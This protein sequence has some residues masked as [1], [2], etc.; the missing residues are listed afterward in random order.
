M[1]IKKYREMD[2][3]E[4]LKLMDKIISDKINNIDN[5]DYLLLVEHLPVYTI[6]RDGDKS[7]IL[8]SEE[9]LNKLNIKYYNVDRGGKITFHGPGQLVGYPILNLNNYGRDLLL[10][11]NTLEKTL[12]EL[13]NPYGIKAERIKGDPGIWLGKNKIAAIGIGAKRWITKHGFALNINTDLNY[14]SYINPCGF[15]NRSVTSIFQETGEKLSFEKVA[16]DY[17]EIFH[18]YFN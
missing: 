3:N 15:T 13:L 17:T 8:I 1:I 12:L 11:L 18:D 9:N 5:N 14:F 4:A 10:Y 2:Y 6:G 7:D 16:N